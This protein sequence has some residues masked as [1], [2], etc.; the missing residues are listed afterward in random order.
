MTRKVS[1]ELALF[2]KLE[3]LGPI[4]GI[5]PGSEAG[6]LT[7]STVIAWKGQHITLSDI[8]VADMMAIVFIWASIVTMN[9]Y[10]WAINLLIVLGIGSNM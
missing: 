4:C 3:S 5:L 10:S 8:F 1:N 2:L 7:A 6:L 9:M